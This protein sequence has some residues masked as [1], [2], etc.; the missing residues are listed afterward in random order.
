MEGTLVSVG[1]Q[2]AGSQGQRRGTPRG[3]WYKLWAEPESLS[4]EGLMV[5]MKGGGRKAGGRVSS[6]SGATQKTPMRMLKPADS[7]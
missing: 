2:T 3:G 1:E 5:G 4:V 6:G 7:P